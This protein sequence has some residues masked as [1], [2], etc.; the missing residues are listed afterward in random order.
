M[1]RL[2]AGEIVVEDIR[3]DEKGGTVRVMAL[4][5]STAQ[6][7]WQV[8]SSCP[9]AR[10]YVHGMKH[11]E[12]LVDEPNWALTH[13]VVDPGWLTPEMDFQFETRRQ[14]YRRMDFELTEGNLR[15]MSGFWLFETVDAGVLIIHELTIQPRVPAPRWLIRRKLA[16]DLPAMM[17]CIRAL[18]NGS[19]SEEMRE[20]DLA[21]CSKAGVQEN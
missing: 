19:L 18:S 9:Q 7:A 13:H 1:A 16:K 4:V 3:L 20:P 11:C 17:A 2:E 10:R 14:P 5:K 15:Q 8:V 21:A 12:V 6:S